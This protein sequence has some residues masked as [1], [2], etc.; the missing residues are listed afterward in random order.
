MHAITALSGYVFGI[1][2][3]LPPKCYNR[4]PVLIVYPSL[5]PV[6]HHPIIT[7]AVDLLL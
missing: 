5:P 2:P 4:P 1:S 3:L 7:A 6:S